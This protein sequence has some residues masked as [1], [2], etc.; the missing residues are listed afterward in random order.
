MITVVRNCDATTTDCRRRICVSDDI[1]E[2]GYCGRH[3]RH[4][5]IP[6]MSNFH[7]VVVRRHIW[8]VSLLIWF[9][10][11]IGMRHCSL[12]S[13][14]PSHLHMVSQAVFVERRR[15]LQVLYMPLISLP[16]STTLGS[17]VRVLFE[18]RNNRTTIMI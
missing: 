18:G 13:S 15:Y 7:S 2:L 4:Q 12:V 17:C 9:Q 16:V 6:V 3:T 5:K 1:E 10:I 8:H 11:F 14:A